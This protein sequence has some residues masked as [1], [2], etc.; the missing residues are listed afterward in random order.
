M[1]NLIRFSPSNELR[2]MQREIDRLF[3]DTFP[4]LH[5][6]VNGD[7][8]KAVWSPRVD[9]AETEDAYV[10]H[11]EVPGIDKKHLTINFHEGELAILG[12][13]EA[14]AKKEGESLVRVERNYGHFYRNRQKAQRG[15]Q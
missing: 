8:K 14:E 4:T 7:E 9:L 10:I 1:A 12:E 15:Q 3:F 11:L 6:N 13:R 5:G 2:R